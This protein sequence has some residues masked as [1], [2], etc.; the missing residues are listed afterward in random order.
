[1]LLSFSGDGTGNICSKLQCKQRRASYLPG[2]PKRVSKRFCACASSGPPQR[3]QPE[4]SR[5]SSQVCSFGY[6]ARVSRPL[7]A[8]VECCMLAPLFSCLKLSAETVPDRLSHGGDRFT[9]CT[10]DLAAA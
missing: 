10:A 1:M 3:M 5:A 8:P 9:K 2:R 4:V 7:T 6:P